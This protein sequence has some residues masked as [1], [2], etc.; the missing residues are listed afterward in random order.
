MEP[1]NNTAESCNSKS[2]TDEDL[3]TFSARRGRTNMLLYSGLAVMQ[4]Y[5]MSCIDKV[6]CRTSSLTGHDWVIE[7]LTGHDG[8][9][10]ENFRMESDIFLKLCSELVNKYGLHIPRK[11]LTVEESVA[12]FLCTIGTGMSNRNLQERFQH[13]G[14]TIH[15]HFHAVLKAVKNMAADVCRPIYDQNYVHPYIQNNRQYH[16]QE[17]NRGQPPHTANESFNKVHSSL[18]SV[19]ERTFGVWKARWAILKDMPAYDMDVQT[20]IVGGSMAIHNFIRRNTEHD[21]VFDRIIND[22]N[23]VLDDEETDAIVNDGQS[24][25]SVHDDEETMNAYRDT[26]RQIVFRRE[27]RRNR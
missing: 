4:Q 18:R 12:I 3:A 13:S 24:S 2:V 7:L 27:N 15:R 6:P 20:A 19:I 26:I 14:E 11:G 16:F 17:F 21:E 23:F 25:S 1:Y 10:H 9:C 5:H 8:R 22:E